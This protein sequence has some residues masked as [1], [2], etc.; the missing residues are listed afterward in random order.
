M[1]AQRNANNKCK[2]QLNKCSYR[3]FTVK[4][5]TTVSIPVLPANNMLD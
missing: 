5:I 2:Q 1:K 4:T 3:K